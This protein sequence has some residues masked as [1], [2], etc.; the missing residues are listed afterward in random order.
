MIEVGCLGCNSNI[1]ETFSFLATSLR[2]AINM[3][4]KQKV[5]FK[6]EPL[7]LCHVVITIFPRQSAQRGREDL[8]QVLYVGPLGLTSHAL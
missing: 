7:F 1:C 2:W 6:Y 5:N 8:S 4:H 3:Y